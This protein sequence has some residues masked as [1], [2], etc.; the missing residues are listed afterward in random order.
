[1][2]NEICC[3]WDS[4]NE[5]LSEKSIQYGKNIIEYFIASNQKKRGNCLVVI[6]RVIVKN[7][8][9]EIAFGPYYSSPNEKKYLDNDRGSKNNAKY[10]L[11]N[12]QYDNYVPEQFLKRDLFL[13][14]VSFDFS[15]ILSNEHFFY[16]L[17]HLED[18]LSF[19]D[20]VNF[21]YSKRISKFSN[22]LECLY[23]GRTSDIFCSKFNNF[24]EKYGNLRKENKRGKYV[25]K[26]RECQKLL[27][28]IEIVSNNYDNSYKNFLTHTEVFFAFKFFIELQKKC[29]SDLLRVIKE[30]G[31]FLFISSNALCDYCSHIILYRM[32]SLNCQFAA[33][34]IHWIKKKSVKKNDKN[35]YFASENSLCET[36]NILN[37]RSNEMK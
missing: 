37:D 26:L 14:D 10:E 22:C 19:L 13:N 27:N 15:E 24:N 2:N 12:I 5:N 1:M 18:F 29:N 6:L 36:V 8:N 11:N 33:T 20:E 30:N 17:D 9:Y 4:N 7:V 21:F 35:R 32:P 31:K 3:C 25:G 28:K 34:S 16:V 23:L